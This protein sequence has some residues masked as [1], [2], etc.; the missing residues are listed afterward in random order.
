MNLNKNLI[1]LILLFITESQV[2]ISQ[3]RTENLPVIDF[4]K[5]YA[6]KVITLRDFADL[7]Y[8]ALETTDDVLL[9]DGSVLSYISD[10]YFFV[11]DNKSGELFIFNRAGKIVSHFNRKGQ[12]PGE[13][14]QSSRLRT[15]FDEKN[16]EIFVCSYSKSIYVYSLSGEYKRTLNINALEYRSKVFNFDDET[17]LFYDEHIID[18]D[19]Q[20]NLN[21]N[22]YSLISKKDGSQISVLDFYLPKRNSIYLT[23]K[24]GKNQRMTAY[25]FPSSM[26]Y[27]KDFVIADISSDTLYLLTQNWTLTPLLTRKPSTHATSGLTNIWTTLL[28]TDKFLLISNFP[29]DLSNPGSGGKSSQ[30]LFEF[31]TSNITE[32]SFIDLDIVSRNGRWQ[33]GDG[34][35]TDKKNITAELIWPSNIINA[36]K[37]KRLKG[38]MEKFAKTLNEDDNPVVRIIKFK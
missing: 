32:V 31:N 27:G 21:T 12:G 6:E 14:P 23:Q 19:N 24:E 11:H 13:Y 2:I 35:A 9:S 18:L 25:F 17:L 22:P 5:T 38:N 20:S 7:E 37:A 33:P 28:T 36:Y 29:I 10:N 26:Y 15:I 8:I 30:L 1:L 3:S 34:P 4:S 16:K